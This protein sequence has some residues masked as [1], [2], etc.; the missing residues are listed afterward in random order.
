M[1][2]TVDKNS[3]SVKMTNL[4]QY[5]IFVDQTVECFEKI[6]SQ[7]SSGINVINIAK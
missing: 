6:N 7:S 1:G 5:I 4:K 3:S 2:N